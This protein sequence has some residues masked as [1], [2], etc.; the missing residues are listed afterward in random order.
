MRFDHWELGFCY[1]EWEIKS[2]SIGTNGSCII[3]GF[4]VLVLL[5]ILD[6]KY[7]FLAFLVIAM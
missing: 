4:Q 7:L 5:K 1:W 2:P 3:R 6:I